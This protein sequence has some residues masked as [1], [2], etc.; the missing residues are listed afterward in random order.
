MNG[1]LRFDTL[2][3][4]L[5]LGRRYVRHE[6]RDKSSTIPSIKRRES[7]AVIPH[8]SFDGPAKHSIKAA[9]GFVVPRT[10]LDTG[11]HH[12]DLPAGFGSL[13]LTAVRTVGRLKFVVGMLDEN[14][15]DNTQGGLAGDDQSSRSSSRSPG[16]RSSRCR[17]VCGE[18]A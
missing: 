18:S 12:S 10:W 9:C 16:G 7:A 13:T 2:G 3:A 17:V 5:T 1:W 15:R 14:H 11:L 8:S 6:V 4:W